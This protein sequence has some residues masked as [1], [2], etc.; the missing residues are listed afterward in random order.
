MKQ[1][2]LQRAFRGLY[3]TREIP[4]LK[5]KF[6]GHFSEYNG[7]VRIEK[8]GRYTTCLAFALSKNFMDTEE[9]MQIGIIQ[10]LLNKVYHTKVS[11]VEQ[12]LY[13]NFIKHLTR[14]AERVESEPL[15]VE[16]FEELNKEYFNSLLEQPNIVFGGESATTLGHYNY[17]KDLVSVSSILS[18]E[19]DLLKYVLYHE[20]LHKKHSFKTTNG[21]AQYHTKEFKD[22]EKKFAIKDAEKKLERFVGKKKLK[23]SF[24]FF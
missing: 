1:E 24:R 22:D 10:Y 23:K 18:E 20:L 17:A 15:L 7:N 4:E 9:E 3:P 14:Y 12:E 11:S 19:R 21:R 13:H 2:L 8:E 16:L 6:S 5:L